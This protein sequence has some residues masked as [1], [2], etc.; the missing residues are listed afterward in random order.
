MTKIQ[1]GITGA[2]VWKAFRKIVRNPKTKFSFY[3]LTVCPQ[4]KENVFRQEAAYDDDEDQI[5]VFDAGIL[6]L[7]VQDYL[8]DYTTFEGDTEAETQKDDFYKLMDEIEQ[9]IKVHYKIADADWV[10]E[11]AGKE[12]EAEGKADGK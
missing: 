2:D 12:D 11:G 7:F 1:F 5:L 8:R 4:G 3:S 9:T 10:A 6:R